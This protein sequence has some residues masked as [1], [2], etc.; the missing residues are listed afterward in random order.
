[1][2]VVYYLINEVIAISN[3]PLNIV[4]ITRFR[5]KYNASLP[6]YTKFLEKEVGR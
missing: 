4:D 3:E 6:K 5:R 1:M 2:Y